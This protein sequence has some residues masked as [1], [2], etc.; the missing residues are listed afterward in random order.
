M[1]EISKLELKEIIAEAIAS[2]SQKEALTWTIDE[3]AKK[4]GI[5]ENKIR[6]L[7][8]SEKCDLPHIKIGKKT[9][10]PVQLFQM[11]LNDKARNNVVI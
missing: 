4:S 5:G 1:M 2:A 6:E 8:A 11:W 7:I 9:V 10:I 3:C